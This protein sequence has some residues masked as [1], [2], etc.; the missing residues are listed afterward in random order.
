MNTSAPFFTDA[1]QVSITR[2]QRA[3]LYMR[4]YQ[5]AA[6][7]FVSQAD[8]AVYTSEVKIWME[9]VETELEILMK[10]IS[11]HVHMI[12]PHFHI[13]A[14]PG[15]PTSPQPLITLVTPSAPAIQWI[16]IPTPVFTNTTLTPPNL[17][18]N[19][20]TLGIGEEGDIAPELR[21]LLPLPLTLIPTLPP[22]LTG[23]SL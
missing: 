3:E 11:S 13:S 22:V 7:D 8:F 4:I 17:F 9:S 10:L 15:D 21:R 1:A 18:G 12:P 6:E 23:L 5:Y 16:N 20:V 19:R 2:K 14:K